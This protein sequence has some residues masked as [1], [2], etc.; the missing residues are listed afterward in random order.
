MP[1]GRFSSVSQ[2]ENDAVLTT[3]TVQDDQ[4]PTNKE[5]AHRVGWLIG[6]M[7]A[8]D[9]HRRLVQRPWT[10][11]VNFFNA[12][13]VSIHEQLL[14]GWGGPEKKNLQKLLPFS[15]FLMMVEVAVNDKLEQK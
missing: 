14:C 15:F 2:G 10:L 3:R 6:G 7:G 4:K 9:H 8:C 1:F 11:A 5:S 12:F 13:N